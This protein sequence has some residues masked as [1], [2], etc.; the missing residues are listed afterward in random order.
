MKLVQIQTGDCVLWI[1][2]QPN[3]LN[4]VKQE[5][6]KLKQFGVKILEIALQLIPI[7]A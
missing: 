3:V 7:F 6:K 1:M 4:V 5:G 2:I